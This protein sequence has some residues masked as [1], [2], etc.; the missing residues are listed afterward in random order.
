MAWT[1]KL[2]VIANRTVDS[3]H[4]REVLLARAQ[5]GPIAITLVAP[6]SRESGD[7]LTGRTAA[8]ERL[9][10]TVAQLRA[11][12]LRVEGIVGDEDPM[13]AVHEVWDPRR[14]DE[15]IVSTLPG[16]TSRWLQHDLPHRVQRYTN[17]RVTHI[18]AHAP[19]PVA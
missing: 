17:A 10:R 3:E 18:I 2:L 9:E 6:A 11:D 1:T 5:K 19:E 4:L 16:G 14:F 12:G 7:V 15:V 13:L 8:A